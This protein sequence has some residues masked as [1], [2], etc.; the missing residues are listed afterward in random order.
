M[1]RSIITGVSHLGQRSPARTSAASTYLLILKSRP[2]VTKRTCL[3]LAF[4][5]VTH[6]VPGAMRGS[7]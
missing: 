3:S 5:P 6:D 7:A 4:A 1:A 2:A